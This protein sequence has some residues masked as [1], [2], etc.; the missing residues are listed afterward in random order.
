MTLVKRIVDQVWRD[1]N[2]SF[3]DAKESHI[4]N[5]VVLT[6]RRP[7][8]YPVDNTSLKIFEAVQLG[9]SISQNR[10]A[11]VTIAAQNFGYCFGY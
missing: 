6:I 11:N 5:V 7:S 4:R 1:W 8:G 9:P 3:F 10:D 2:L